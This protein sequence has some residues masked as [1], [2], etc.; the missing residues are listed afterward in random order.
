MSLAHDGAAREGLKRQ[1][2]EEIVVIDR[3]RGER[4]D[5][6]SAPSQVRNCRDGRRRSEREGSITVERARLIFVTLLLLGGCASPQRQ[7]Q[8]QPEAPNLI[9]ESWR[10]T[11]CSQAAAYAKQDCIA[12]HESMDLPPQLPRPAL[13][14]DASD[15]E[16][17]CADHAIR[18][19]V[20][21]E[22]FLDR[23]AACKREHRTPEEI[24]EQTRKDEAIRAA[25]DDHLATV[26]KDPASAIQYAVGDPV[27]CNLVANLPTEIEDSLC[28]CYRVN[29]KNSMGGYTGAELGVVSLVSQ[30]PPY[31]MIDVPKD[32]INY[33]DG[34]GKV[35]PRDAAQ[36]HALVR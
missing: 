33:P 6:V 25:L 35:V 17:N 10:H 7:P 30:N 2:R 18:Q 31:P 22:D 20:L 3:R 15:V 28:I 1:T 24:A 13:P 36:I 32:L 27:S 23:V 34:C 12:A 26:L 21:G 5:R 9:R 29:A 4:D 14:P 16:K 19:G 11:S 8:A